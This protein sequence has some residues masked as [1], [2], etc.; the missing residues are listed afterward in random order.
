MIVAEEIPNW[1]ELFCSMSKLDLLSWHAIANTGM[2]EQSR[3]FLQSAKEEGEQLLL[4]CPVVVKSEGAC[5]TFWVV[6]CSSW[7]SCDWSMMLCSIGNLLWP[8]KLHLQVI[9]GTVICCPDLEFSYTDHSRTIL[10][11]GSYL[12]CRTEPWKSSWMT[13]LYQWIPSDRRQAWTSCAKG[14]REEARS[15]FY[16]MGAHVHCNMHIETLVHYLVIHNL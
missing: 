16:V 12:C 5:A 15:C 9:E 11:W 13:C 2:V 7:L 1:C 6:Q 3:Y 4:N 10:S 14:D 8:D